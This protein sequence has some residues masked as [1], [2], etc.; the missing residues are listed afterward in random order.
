MDWFTPQMAITALLMAFI[1]TNM[2]WY[3]A[4]M[5]A[6]DAR[7]NARRDEPAALEMVISSKAKEIHERIDTLNRDVADAN[8]EMLLKIIDI[9]KNGKSHG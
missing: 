7:I 2:F 8:K 6:T 5:A 1:G 3:K 9:I 4:K